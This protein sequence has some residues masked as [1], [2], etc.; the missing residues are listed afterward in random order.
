ML[1][2]LSGILMFFKLE[3]ILNADSPMLLTLSGITKFSKLEQPANAY[4]PILSTVAGITMFSK[5]EQPQKV[6]SPISQGMTELANNSLAE[7]IGRSQVS[8][9]GE[10]QLNG[11][12]L[13]YQNVGKLTGKSENFIYNKEDGSIEYEEYTGNNVLKKHYYLLVSY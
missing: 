10:S 1:L 11:N 7:A 12:L 4:F 9:R 3:H 2:T 13:E 6:K 5:L 8:F